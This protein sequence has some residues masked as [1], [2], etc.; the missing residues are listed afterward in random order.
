M[1][2]T[3]WSA[4][5]EGGA[6]GAE[7]LRLHGVSS[8]L[9]QGVECRRAGRI[10]VFGGVG[11]PLHP[12][13]SSKTR[14]PRRLNIAPAAPP[15]RHTNRARRLHRRLS[16]AWTSRG[17]RRIFF[18]CAERR[19]LDELLEAARTRIEGSSRAKPLQR[20]ERG[21]LIID[22]RSDVDRRTRRHRSRLTPHPAHRARMAPRPGQPMAQ[23]PH[24]RLDQ[25]LL[26]L[27]DHGCSSRLAAATSSTL[28]SNKPAT[29]SAA[30]R[31]EGRGTSHRSA[32]PF[33]RP[34]P[35]PAGMEK[36]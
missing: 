11:D 36:A 31:L 2:A 16:R 20:P 26:L 8:N 13:P 21:T 34:T 9:E 24:R 29:S 7:L 25:Q 4:R 18:F 17:G 12:A 10:P 28:A 32:P 33:Q 22:I 23:P 30:R 27:C 19:T 3:S 5:L 1:K 14:G 6:A 35:E 15:S